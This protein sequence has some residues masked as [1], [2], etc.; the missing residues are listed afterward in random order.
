MAIL[1]SIPGLEVTV[2]INGVTAKEYAVPDG[3]EVIPHHMT[4]DDF[5]GPPNFDQSL[6][7]TSQYIE[8]KPGELYGFDIKKGHNFQARSNHIAYSLSLDGHPFGL[9][10]DPTKRKQSWDRR[11]D[12]FWSGD[13]TE[14]YRRHKFQFAA[15]DISTT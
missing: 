6:P 8:A 9:S 5:H 10:H 2:V 4:R 12:G 1:Q 15:L 13:P 7:Y 3:E 14:G 11:S